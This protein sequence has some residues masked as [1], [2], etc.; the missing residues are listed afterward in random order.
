MFSKPLKPAQRLLPYDLAVIVM[1]VKL[2]ETFQHLWQ[3]PA[4]PQQPYLSLA[5]GF[6]P[7]T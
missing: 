7:R 3:L 2:A 1:L 5:T 4:A 6:N